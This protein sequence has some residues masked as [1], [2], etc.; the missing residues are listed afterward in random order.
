[1][2]VGVEEAVDQDLLEVGAE[3]FV[4]EIGAV[5]LQPGQRA[6]LGD[7]AALDELQREHARGGEVLERLG[8]DEPLEVFEIGPQCDQVAAFV[9]EVELPDQAALELIEH[10]AQLE[11][12]RG[13]GVRVG[14]FGDVAQDLEVFGDPSVEIRAL[15]L[16]GD[17][18]PVPQRRFMDLG[19]AGRRHRYR[20]DL[21]EG[22]KIAQKVASR[23][24]E[25][26]I[27]TDRPFVPRGQ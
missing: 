22:Y 11:A 25:V 13:I 14:E 5:H 8:H 20:I 10:G 9:A 4:G 26:G 17:Q 24:L 19:Q 3:E 16:D 6:D 18:A 7:L 27:P 15:H 1:M 23:A 21:D 2:R 12:V